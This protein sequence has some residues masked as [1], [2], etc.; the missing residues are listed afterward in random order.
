MEKGILKDDDI[1]FEKK[2]NEK[3][4]DAYRVNPRK[5][6]KY[7]ELCTQELGYDVSEDSLLY[8]K[9]KILKFFRS[10]KNRMFLYCGLLLLFGLCS[11]KGF[12]F[13][14]FGMAFFCAGIIM[15]LFEK[16]EDKGI[17]IFLFT[18][19]LV[20]LII[21]YGG[22]SITIYNYLLDSK[23]YF[24][25]YISSIICGII[26]FFRVFLI[27]LSTSKVFNKSNTFLYFVAA[28]FI[29]ALLNLFIF[30]GVRF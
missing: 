21:M 18:H 11:L 13:Y 5:T 29:L 17:I 7:M 6:L 25:M 1:K 14:Y 27:A 24:L 16:G 20:G 28:F 4:K 3:F 23:F 2:F 15:N 30:C 26:G 8:S 10:E 22:F 12:M 19:G 9:L